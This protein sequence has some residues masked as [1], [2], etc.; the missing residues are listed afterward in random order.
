MYVLSARLCSDVN[1]NG[2]SDATVRMS[3]LYLLTAGE[4]IKSV[5]NQVVVPSDSEPNGGTLFPDSGCRYAV[6]A[7]NFTTK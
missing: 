5:A 2:T 4:D 1:L 7:S 6:V 3:P